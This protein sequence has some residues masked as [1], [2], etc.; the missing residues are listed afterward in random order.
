MKKINCDER[1]TFDMTPMIDCTFQL[2]IFF[3]LTLNYSQQDLDDRIKLPASELAKPVEVVQDTSIVL[4]LTEQNTIYVAGEEMPV[5]GLRNL[6]GRE[7]KLIE[8]SPRRR[9]LKEAIV[10]IRADAASQTGR[11][12]QI[13]KIAQEMGF[14]KFV[15]RA[16][17]E[18]G[19]RPTGGRT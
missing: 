2:V 13:I 11:V 12:Q 19:P 7:R 6:L 15:L 3:M 16:K 9:N 18:M 4:Q 17:E 5:S 1:L 8:A 10:V 14:E